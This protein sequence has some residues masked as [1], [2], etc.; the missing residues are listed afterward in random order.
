[1]ELIFNHKQLTDQSIK[2]RRREK[3]VGEDQKYSKGIFRLQLA[4]CHR[5][6]R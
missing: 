3:T 6:N 4:S 1:M 2:A 5:S